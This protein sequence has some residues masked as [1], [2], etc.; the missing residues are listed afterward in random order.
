MLH[1]VVSD[2][3][4]S[5]AIGAMPVARDWCPLCY[6]SGR[7]AGGEAYVEV[8]INEAAL[9]LRHSDQTV[10]LRILLPD[11]PPRTRGSNLHKQKP[12]APPRTAPAIALA[13]MK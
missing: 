9:W 6:G 7:D 10:P 5:L 11:M 1:E 12:K 3:F 8:S 4:G 13:T 2:R